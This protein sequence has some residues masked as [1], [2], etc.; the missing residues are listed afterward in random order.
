MGDG[1]P[2]ESAKPKRRRIWKT[3]GTLL[4]I[5]LAL[6]AS[7]YYVSIEAIRHVFSLMDI[8][9]GIGFYPRMY[10]QTHD[11]FY[12]PL[13]SEPGRLIYESESIS[14]DDL[15]YGL[16]TAFYWGEPGRREDLDPSM[17]E[18]EFRRAARELLNDQSY[19]Y[20]GYFVTNEIEGRAFIEAYKQV[21]ARGGSFEDDL[22]VPQ[23]QG[24]FGSD[25]LY[26]LRNEEALIRDIKLTQ[27]EARKFRDSAI[28]LL[29]NPH[30]RAKAFFPPPWRDRAAIY[31][32]GYFG[33]TCRIPGPF[34]CTEE[35]LSALE[36]LDRMS[37][38]GP[39]A[40][41]ER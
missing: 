30:K 18:E 4:V 29:Q 27:D 2:D 14:K 1:L 8:D 20:L 23:G 17:S 35:F 16:N 19:Y 13:S 22:P 3:L 11:G 12:P 6:M 38:N 24:N 39:P 15:L 28:L 36:E 25:R 33:D 34:P 32:A 9:N 26:R 10:G 41:A 31:F 40:R 5:L 21:I 7:I 37:D